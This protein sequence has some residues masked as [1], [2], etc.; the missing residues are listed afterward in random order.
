MY[1]VDEERMSR[2][3]SRSTYQTSRCVVVV[4]SLSQPMN[5][6][7]LLFLVLHKFPCVI[8]RLIFNLVNPTGFPFG[9]QAILFTPSSNL[10]HPSTRPPLITF[11]V[12]YGALALELCRWNFEVHTWKAEELAH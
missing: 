10:I 3:I 11:C 6:V 4:S 8:R 7:H 2:I 1:I 9:C 12:Y 5:T